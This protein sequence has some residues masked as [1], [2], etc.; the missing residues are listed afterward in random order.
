[1]T[2]IA[3]KN[4]VLATDSREI[5]GIYIITENS[6]KIHK[7]KH[8]VIATCGSVGF[9][10]W[11]YNWMYSNFMLSP[12]SHVDDGAEAFLIDRKDKRFFKVYS[13][14]QK[15]EVD[16][17]LIHTSGSAHARLTL[18]LN[19]YK[20]MTPAQAI[21]KIA[22]YDTSINNKIQQVKCW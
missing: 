12:P 21:K 13:N 2:A 4:G 9:C 19:E 18:L 1:M 14:G 15:E 16:P 22:K 11:S 6:K 20:K 10:A 7:Y 8:F 5:D 3:W 17:K